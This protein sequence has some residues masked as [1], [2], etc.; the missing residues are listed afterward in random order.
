MR[1]SGQKD[2]GFQ[3]RPGSR[4]TLFRIQKTAFEGLIGHLDDP[5]SQTT[6]GITGGLRLQ[7][8][9]LFVNNHRFAQDGVRSFKTEPVKN[10]LELCDTLLVGLQ[11][12]EISYMVFRVSG[13]AVSRIRGIEMSPRRGKVSSRAVPL[14]MDVKAMFAW[15]QSLNICD[16]ANSL[17]FFAE[18]HLSFYLAVGSWA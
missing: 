9:S 6:S 11:V 15:G 18:G 8:I 5:A 7:V 10:S 1:A 16:Y 2:D 17:R 12:A 4:Y 14:F 3:G 13:R